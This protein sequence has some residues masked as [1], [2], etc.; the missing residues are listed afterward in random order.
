MYSLPKYT[1]KPDELGPILMKL[2]EKT[3]R[4]M[5]RA[6]FGAHGIHL[7]LVYGDFTHWHRGRSVGTTLYATQDIY[8]KAQLLMGSQPEKKKVAKISVSCFDLIVQPREQLRLFEDDDTKNWAAS[9][10]MDKINDRYGEFVITP[11]LMM[12][13]SE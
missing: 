8:R 2:C 6:G 3:G 5:R 1:D 10:A 13:M 7:A 9:D 11:A 4:R 12:G